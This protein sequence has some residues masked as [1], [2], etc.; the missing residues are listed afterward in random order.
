M[1]EN[2]Y[3]AIF[4]RRQARDLG[5]KRYF[6]GKPC[7]GGGHIDYRATVNG[8]CYECKRGK[9][10]IRNIYLGKEYARIKS[11]VWRRE[12]QKASRRHQLNYRNNNLEKEKIRSR[13]RYK[14]NKEKAKIYRSRRRAILRLA[15]GCYT[16]HEL[17][18]LRKKQKDKCIY[19]NISIKK[20]YHADHIMPLARGG[21]NWI[22]NIQLLCPTC[23]LR[24]NDKDPIVFAQENGRLL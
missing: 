14:N 13:L 4:T 18:D 22:S 5:L 23:N 15:E 10:A 16:V 12:N 3:K 21:S 9:Q 6:T 19:C 8:D 7:K 1:A 17:H 20:S 2:N 24:K 11:F